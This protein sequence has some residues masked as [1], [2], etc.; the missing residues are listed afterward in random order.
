[1]LIFLKTTDRQSINFSHFRSFPALQLPSILF[2]YYRKW[3]TN[4][5]C[6]LNW[7][8]LLSLKVKKQL[9]SMFNAALNPSLFLH[10]VPMIVER[11]QLLESTTGDLLPKHFQ[12]LLSHLLPHCHQAPSHHLPDPLSLCDMYFM[13]VW[14]FLIARFM[15]LCITVSS[16]R[17]MI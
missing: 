1:M 7:C 14:P 16:G 5:F 12:S 8:D 9:W 15:L 11:K 6:P 13:A 10:T 4:D 3:N 17:G 2:C